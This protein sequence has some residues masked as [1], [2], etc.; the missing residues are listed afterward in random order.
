MIKHIFIDLDDTLFDFHRAERTALSAMLTELGIAP[1]DKTAEL[2][3]EI[4]DA[5]WKMLE[6]GEIE[7]DV[8]LTKRFAVLFDT[9]GVRA[10]PAL[11]KKSYEY[12]LGCC[13]FFIDGARELL[14]QLYKKYDLYLASNGTDSV[15]TRRIAGAGIGKYFKGTFISQR[16]GADKPHNEYFE[17]CFSR[18]EG[19]DRTCAV[20]IGDSLSSDILGG[21]NAGITTVWYN[22]CRKSAGKILPDYEI[23]AL[24]ELPSLLEEI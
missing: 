13:H 3:S 7:R 5:H 2:Y 16:I 22:P 19:F 10:D 4:N 24:E 20:I 14:E 11:A 9:I 23:H 17:R 6:R 21:K 18:I 8:L 15:Q 1:T 12:N